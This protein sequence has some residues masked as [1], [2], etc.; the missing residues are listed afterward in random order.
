M[1][2]FPTNKKEFYNSETEQPKMAD[3][4]AGVPSVTLNGNSTKGQGHSREGS[5]SSD[6]EN[7]TNGHVT[8]S[9]RSSDASSEG[10]QLIL[11][12]G[13]RLKEESGTETAYVN[14]AFNG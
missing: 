1:N 11:R 7:V 4:V 10:G 14:T 12:D 3:F 9:R 2:R 5:V 6:K 8:S 13:G